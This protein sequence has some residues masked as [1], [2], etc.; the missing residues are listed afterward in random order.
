MV[1]SVMTMTPLPVT[2]VPQLSILRVAK[3]VPCQTKTS[4]RVKGTHI[5]ASVNGKTNQTQLL[6][7]EEYIKCILFVYLNIILLI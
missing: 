2:L 6:K 4:Y 3:C 7:I 5:M 1:S